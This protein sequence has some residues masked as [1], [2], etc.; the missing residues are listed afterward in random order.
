MVDADD[1]EAM[2]SV[3]EELQP[4]AAGASEAAGD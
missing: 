2:E 3:L 1:P 4:H